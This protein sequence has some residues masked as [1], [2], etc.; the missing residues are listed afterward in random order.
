MILP[1]GL[2]CVMASGTD[3]QDEPKDRIG[4]SG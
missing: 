2:T 4:T 3:W 1:N